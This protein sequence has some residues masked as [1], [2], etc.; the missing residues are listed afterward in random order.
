MTL[1]YWYGVYGLPEVPQSKGTVLTGSNAQ[2]LS[3]MGGHVGEFLIV[4]TKRMNNITGFGIVEISG[5]IP[6]SG[7]QL[8]SPWQPIRRYDHARVSRQFFDGCPQNRRFLVR[9]LA[10]LK[11]AAAGTT[12]IG[13]LLWPG[14]LFGHVPIDGCL[15]HV[16]RAITAGRQN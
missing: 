10:V 6:G 11:V 2:S 15:P 12:R 14:Q 9:G 13:S 8:L 16:S 5:P 1:K 4:S 3:M 7:Y